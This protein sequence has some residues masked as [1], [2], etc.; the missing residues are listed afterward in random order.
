MDKEALMAEFKSVVDTAIAT[1]LKDLVGAEVASKVNETVSKMRLEKALTGRDI[2]GLD[3]ETKSAFVKD[4]RA[5]SRGEKAA[6]L[7]D[8]DQTGGYLVP[9]E[10]HAAILNIAA[11]VGLVSRDALRFPMSS[12][13]LNVP[14]YTG[15]VLQ[16]D[17]EGEDSEGSETSVAFG[18][19]KLNAKTWMLIF[20]IGNTLLADSSPAVA[21]WLLAMAAEGLAYK[22]DREGFVGG[23]FAGSPFVGILGSADVTVHTMATGATQFDDFGIAEASDAIGALPTAALNDAA[24]Y[25]HRTVWAKLRGRSTSGVF[26][27]GQSQPMLAN[28]R[29]ENG[30]Q[31]VG[32]ILGYPVYTTDVLPANSTT[33]VSTKF[34]VFGNLKLGVFIGDRGPVEVA[35]SDSA[36]V[37]GKNVFAA[38]QTAIRLTHRHAVTIGLPAALVALKTAAS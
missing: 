3:D 16:G 19:A 12:D 26:E 1:N 21:D 36:T 14:R 7:S 33:A 6:L 10:L 25:F 18:D 27:F 32:D 9:K 37:G 29:K 13:E 23:T 5:I 38:N 4:I 31:P 15:A 22:L 35:K 30:I 8:N 24:F 11:T 34:G 2:T 20:R 17:Y 28:L